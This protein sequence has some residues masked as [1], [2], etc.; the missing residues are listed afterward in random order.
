MQGED[1][2]L[3]SLAYFGGAILDPATWFI[4]CSKS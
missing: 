3:I 4:T 1:G 2:G